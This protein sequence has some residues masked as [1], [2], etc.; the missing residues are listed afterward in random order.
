VVAA[1]AV[2]F[3]E[4]RHLPVLSA[5][6]LPAADRLAVQL[7]SWYLGSCVAVLGVVCV[8]VLGVVG[9]GHTVGVLRNR[10]AGWV[11]WVFGWSRL[12]GRLLVGA[13]GWCGVVV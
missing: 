4:H 11:V 12:S 1:G 2:W 7:C 10:A 9:W 6:E 5:S 3:V 13:G 8:P